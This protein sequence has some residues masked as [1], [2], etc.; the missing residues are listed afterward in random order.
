MKN[1]QS[2]SEYDVKNVSKCK[3]MVINNQK[4]DI[5]IIIRHKFSIQ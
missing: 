4:S 1:H 2:I 5:Q 3:Q